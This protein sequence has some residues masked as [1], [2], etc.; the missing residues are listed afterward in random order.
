M[1]LSKL[2]CTHKPQVTCESVQVAGPPYGL[3]REG[4]PLC[5]LHKKAFAWSS[6]CR[7]KCYDS[8][9]AVGSFSAS[10]VGRSYQP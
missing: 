8:D 4:G 1:L 10:L 3:G 7:L 6:C 9:H 2:A 5:F